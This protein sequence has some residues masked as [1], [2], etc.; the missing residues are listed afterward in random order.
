VAGA[1]V[2]RPGQ[3]PGDL[4]RGPGPASALRGGAAGAMA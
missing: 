2:W 3:R 1:S 4:P